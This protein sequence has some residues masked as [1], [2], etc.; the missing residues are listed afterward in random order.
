MK[1]IDVDQVGENERDMGELNVNEAGCGIGSSLLT[2]R[3]NIRSYFLPS[4]TLGAQRSIKSVMASK[5]TLEMADMPIG[6][7]FYH[8]CIPLNNVNS[9]YF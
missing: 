6:K 5:I 9:I 2:P 7:F 3:K 1:T 4:T 8:A